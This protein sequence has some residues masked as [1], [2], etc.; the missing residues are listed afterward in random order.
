MGC[1]W[2]I[3]DERLCMGCVR[4]KEFVM[5]IKLVGGPLD[6]TMYGLNLAPDQRVASRLPGALS[7]LYNDNWHGYAA[8]IDDMMRTHYPDDLVVEYHYQGHG[9]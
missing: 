5:K 9:E 1:G 8:S 4:S 2:R 7:F 6:G 3:S